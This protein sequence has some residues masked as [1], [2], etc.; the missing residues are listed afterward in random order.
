MHAARSVG[1]SHLIQD[2]Q[3]ALLLG[4]SVKIE[5]TAQDLAN[6]CRDR[7]DGIQ[8]K[9]RLLEN[10]TDAPSPDIAHGRLW[11]K[12][13]ILFAQSHRSSHDFTRIWKKPHHGKCR[14]GFA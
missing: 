12:K 4:Y 9:H 1:Y 14:H 10:H 2:F 7:H 8:A 13:Q 5:M 6:L 11:Q 3:D